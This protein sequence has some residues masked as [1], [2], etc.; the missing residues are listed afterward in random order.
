SAGCGNAALQVGGLTTLEAKNEAGPGLRA[1]CELLKIPPVLSFGTCTDTGRITLLVTAIADALG[2]D[3]SQLP[4]AV[5]A[6]EYME[7]KAT[8]DAIFALAFGLY[9]HVAPMPPVGG[10]PRLVKLLTEDI[11]GLTGGKIAVQTDMVEA[12]NGIEAHINKKRKAL[13]LPV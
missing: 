13:G 10:A 1:V 7:Q 3:P 11:E 12:A 6:P 5:T 2:V 4:V 8:I 9:T